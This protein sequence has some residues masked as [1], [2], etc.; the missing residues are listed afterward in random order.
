MSINAKFVANLER[1]LVT[2]DDS[3]NSIT[4]SRDVDGHL[5]AN[6]GAVQ[7]SPAGATVFNTDLIKVVGGDGNDVI[8]LDE[9]NGALVA[10]NLFGGDGN[11]TLTGGS[12]ND[13]LLGQ[14]GNDTLFGQAGNDILSGDGG[15]DFIAGGAGNDTIN[16]GAGNDF[17]DGDQGHDVAFLGTGDDIFRWDQGDGS[18]VVEGGSGFDEMVFNGFGVSENFTLSANGDRASFT[19]VQGNILMD[20]HDIEKVT[21]NAFGGAD[22]VTINDPTGTGIKDIDIN[23]GAGGVGD[24]D[25]IFIRDDDHVTVVN[26]GNGN[27][28]ITGLSGAEVHVTG[29]ELTQDQLVI[30][31]DV[32]HF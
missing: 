4:I 10:A 8:T 23:L 28:T 17:I 18:D 25:T 15:N 7:I 5:L 21:V 20:L 24:N 9:T 26:N 12:G 16:G 14:N 32:F 30:N 13:H 6:G 19:R 31:G 27:L 22:T 29:F 3:D 2:G 11:D 1:L